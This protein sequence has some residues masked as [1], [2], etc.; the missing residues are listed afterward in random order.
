MGK[1]EVHALPGYQFEGREEIGAVGPG[2][3]VEGNGILDASE[4]EEGGFAVGRLRE[5]LQR[6][7]GDNPERAF[8]T[9]E[10][11]LQVR[12]PVVFSE[13]GPAIDDAP[14]WQDG[15]EPEDE[16]AQHAVAQDIQ[17]A[18]IGGDG[19]ADLCRTLGAEGKGEEPVP[20]G[21]GVLDRLHDAACLD[22]GCVVHG[23][24]GA[25]AVHAAK[26]DDDIRVPRGVA[27][28]DK[29]RVAALGHGHEALG[30][31]IGENRRHLCRRGRED[32]AERG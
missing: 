25:D 11:L 2:Q 9:D 32:D 7:G 16:I 21:G 10:E 29:T 6:G 3:G 15:F 18:R 13:P 17:A 5:Q 24:D 20:G 1:C 4:R 19:A 30:V 12:A 28:P 27:A 26:V 22:L 8:R 23:I 14:V 31:A